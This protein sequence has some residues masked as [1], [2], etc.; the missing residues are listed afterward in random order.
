MSEDKDSR[1]LPEEPSTDKPHIDAGEVKSEGT[2]TVDRTDFPSPSRPPWWKRLFGLARRKDHDPTRYELENKR[3]KA[4]TLNRN[5]Y[6]GALLAILF[7]Q[8]GMA[9]WFLYMAATGPH[10]PDKA[11]FYLSDQVLGF[12]LGSVVVEVI[13]LVYGI[14]RGYFPSKD[15]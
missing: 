1:Q 6:A 13:G 7:I 5:I 10:T 3:F 12:Y 14:V 15:N 9:H 8:L 2:T 11:G 4:D